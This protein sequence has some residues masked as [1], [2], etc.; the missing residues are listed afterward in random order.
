MRHAT[1]VFEVGEVLGF[2]ALNP[3]IDGGTRHLHKLTDT[4][5][6]PAL[7]VEFDD[8]EACLILVGMMVIRAKGKFPLDRAGTVLPE[9]FDR[10]VVN[11]IVGLV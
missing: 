6:T 2:K 5:L 4:A 7:I 8:L 1:L 3:A 9:P 10:L 11:T